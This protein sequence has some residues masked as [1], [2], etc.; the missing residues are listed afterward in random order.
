MLLF[1][2]Q[3]KIIINKNLFNKMISIC[4]R[5]VNKRDFGYLSSVREKKLDAVTFQNH[6]LN[7]TDP[8]NTEERNGLGLL[9]T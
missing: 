3:A 6:A 5:F 8:D 9:L 7:S 1:K 4:L 2:F